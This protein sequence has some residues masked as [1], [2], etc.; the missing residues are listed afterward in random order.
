MKKLCT[1]VMVMTLSFA[2]QAQKKVVLM[3][4]STAAGTGASTIA[5]SVFGRL[6]A[7]YNTHTW[8]NIAVPGRNTNQALDNGTSG[9]IYEAL[10]LDPDVILAS[11]PSNDVAAGFTNTQTINNLINLQTIAAANGVEIFFLGT[12]PRDFADEPRRIQLS[13]QNDLILSTFTTKAINVYPL[14]VRTGGFIAT[15]VAVGD[16]IH[17]NDEGH[18][19][20]FQAVVDNSIFNSLLPI[21][22]TDFRA[23]L[24]NRFVKLSW[25][26]TADD[27]HDFVGVEKSVDGQVFSEIGKVRPNALRTQLHNYSFEDRQPAIGKNYYRLAL[28]DKNGRREYSRTIQLNHLVHG[29]MAA[30]PVPATDLLHISTVQSTRSNITIVVLDQLGNTLYQQNKTG[31]KGINRFSIPVNQLA[32]GMYVIRVS[33][34]DGINTQRFIKQ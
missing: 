30:Y 25:Q 22:V 16:Q 19:R 10:A 15:D 32:N 4:S 26:A 33:S 27:L 29:T 14:L 28:V 23:A 3:G 6:Q 24:Q 9:N 21:V 1:A 20:I 8:Y 2:I 34:P 7:Y 13:T 31:E 18:R 12:Q 5:L 11:Y 17:V